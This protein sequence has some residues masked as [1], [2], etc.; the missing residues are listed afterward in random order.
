[1]IIK[2]HGL[3]VVVV[4]LLHHHTRVSLVIREVER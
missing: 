1:M 4:V 3:V 2:V